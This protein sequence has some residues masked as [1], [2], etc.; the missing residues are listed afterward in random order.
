MD[1]GFLVSYHSPAAEESRPEA[2]AGATVDEAIEKGPKDEA[3]KK[4]KSLG[5]AAPLKLGVDFFLFMNFVWAPVPFY[6]NFVIY[7]LWCRDNFMINQLRCR[8]NF[9]VCWLWCRS[10]MNWYYLPFSLP[11]L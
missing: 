5:D 10:L 11:L 1:D 7:R 3:S 2:E 6:L 8:D 4:M 9:V